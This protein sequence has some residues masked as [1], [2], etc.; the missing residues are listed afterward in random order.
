MVMLVLPG[1]TVWYRFSTGAAFAAWC[2]SINRRFH[3]IDANNAKSIKDGL[4]KSVIP[5]KAGIQFV[6]STVR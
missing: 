5:A 1:I 4:I 6:H 3:R 2:L